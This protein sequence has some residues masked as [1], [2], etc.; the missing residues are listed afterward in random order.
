M[1][2]IQEMGNARYHRRDTASPGSASPDKKFVVIF[3]VGPLR[4]DPIG[5]KI[6]ETRSRLNKICRTRIRILSYTLNTPKTLFLCLHL[7]VAPQVGVSSISFIRI[8]D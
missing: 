4:V 8:G 7:V 3:S 2:H 1:S 6:F 5:S